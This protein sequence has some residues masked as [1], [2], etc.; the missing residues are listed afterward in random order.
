MPAP[1]TK[2]PAT[3]AASGHARAPWPNSG[4]RARS[5]NA[6]GASTNRLAIRSWKVVPISATKMLPQ[7]ATAAQ[8]SGSQRV[9]TVSPRPVEVPASTEPAMSQTSH[10]LRPWIA[11]SATPMIGARTRSS[12]GYSSASSAGLR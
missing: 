6:S 2:P 7:P 9:A 5:A 8:S 12:A 3:V 10:R 1:T 11:P 4:S